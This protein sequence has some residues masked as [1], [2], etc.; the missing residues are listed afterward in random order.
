MALVICLGG[1]ILKNCYLYSVKIFSIKLGDTDCHN[2]HSYGTNT[3]R[4]VEIFQRSGSR[5]DQRAEKYSHRGHHL[6]RV[7]RI[8][9]VLLFVHNNLL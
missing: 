9:C 3:K 1:D 7:V 5:K 6:D 8:N 4:Y 2:Y